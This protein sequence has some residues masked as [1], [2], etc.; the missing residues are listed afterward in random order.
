MNTFGWGCKT[1]KPTN[2]SN[3]L[4]AGKGP[5]VEAVYHFQGLTLLLGCWQCLFMQVSML[6]ARGHSTRPPIVVVYVIVS[7]C[8]CWLRS[9]DKG[10]EPSTNRSAP[11]QSSRGPV[12][13]EKDS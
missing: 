11:S 1:A 8:S 4:F 2:G 3:I 9:P 5:T 6:S 10:Y 7:G 13:K 12:K